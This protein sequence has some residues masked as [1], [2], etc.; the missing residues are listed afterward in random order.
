MMGEKS[1]KGIL[2]YTKKSK[3][4]YFL[5]Q[6]DVRTLTT[7]NKKRGSKKRILFIPSKYSLQLRI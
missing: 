5:T 3:I 6:F 1:L 7:T 4:F 2:I